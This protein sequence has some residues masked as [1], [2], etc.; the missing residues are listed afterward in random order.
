MAC[1]LHLTHIFPIQP[2]SRPKI[3]ARALS[4]FLPAPF[5][6]QNRVEQNQFFIGKVT[7]L[8]WNKEAKNVEVKAVTLDKDSLTFLTTTDSS[9]RFTIDGF[10]IADTTLFQFTSRGGKRDKTPYY[11]EID[12]I[13]PRPLH[14]PFLPLFKRRCK[15]T[16][17]ET[18]QGLSHFDK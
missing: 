11:V 15:T 9:G 3:P 5:M 13:Y 8:L 10:D 16:L 14:T 6:P 1:V 18:V 17:R 2:T 4:Y 7:S 12:R